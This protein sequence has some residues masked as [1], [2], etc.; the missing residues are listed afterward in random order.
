MTVSCRNCMHS[1]H[2]WHALVCKI[3]AS[4]A[5][6]DIYKGMCARASR[7]ANENARFD[8]RCIDLAKRCP[9]YLEVMA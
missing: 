6:Q 5:W 9:F 1:T 2:D 8:Q 4:P 7:S 3:G